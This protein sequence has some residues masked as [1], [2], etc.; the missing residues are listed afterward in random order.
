[1]NKTL[2]KQCELRNGIDLSKSFKL[3]FV[4]YCAE[5]YDSAKNGKIE[6]EVFK[7]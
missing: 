7:R 4:N 5:A 6:Y 2:F 3:F 1:M